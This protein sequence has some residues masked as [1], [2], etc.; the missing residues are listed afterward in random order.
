VSDASGAAASKFFELTIQPPFISTAL[1]RVGSFAQIASGSGWQTELT[2]VNLSAAAVTGR[3]D[4][5]GDAGNPLALPLT[6]PQ[7]GLNTVATSVNLNLLPNQSLVIDSASA[8]I[9][10]G[11]ADV[12]ATGPLTGYA[13]FRQLEAGTRDAEA[14]TPLDTRLSSLL[15]LPYNNADGFRT[16]IGLVNQE[17]T[18]QSVTAILLDQDGSQ[19]ASNPIILRALGHASFFLAEWFPQTTNQRGTIYLQGPGALT[20]LGL[21]F[22]PTGSF[23]SLPIMH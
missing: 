13:V 23:T 14:T 9:A 20:G 7:S 1:P 16:G 12:Q 5:Y 4:F 2:L 10:V 18:A 17:T 8:S 22:G 15:V 11:W 19:L 3:I 6:F 21:Q